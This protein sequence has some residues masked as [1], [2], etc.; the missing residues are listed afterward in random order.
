MLIIP[1]LKKRTCLCA[2]FSASMTWLSVGQASVLPIATP[3][4]A[5]KAAQDGNATT[6]MQ[7]SRM[8]H[9][10]G[11]DWL[12]VNEAELDNMRGGFDMPGGPGGPGG[13]GLPGGPD[14]LGRP[15]ANTE[16][17][18]SIGIERAVYINGRLSTTN[19]FNI[20]NIDKLTS[21]QAKQLNA[22]AGT[23]NLVQTGSGNTFQPGPMPQVT[24]GTVVQ[25][26]LNNQTIKSVTTINATANSLGTFKGINTQLS[27]QDALQNAMG[28][29]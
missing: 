22:T 12:A 10:M 28:S 23:I 16:L 20:T 15:N 25:N 17:K 13:P 8:R 18:V 2:L 11:D 9:A 26:T 1:T 24:T 4:N 14:K 21:E 19:G 27:L 3:S 7:E 6:A 5:A 29:R